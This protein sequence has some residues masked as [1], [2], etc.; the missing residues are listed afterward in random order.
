MAAGHL[1]T[2]VQKGSVRKA[3]G[4]EILGYLVCRLLDVDREDLET[5]VLV[6]CI[7]FL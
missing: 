6:A 3:F 1:T 2:R 4:P 5:L 7:E